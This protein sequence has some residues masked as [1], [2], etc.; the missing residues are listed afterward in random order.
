MSCLLILEAEFL[1]WLIFNTQQPWGGLNY[2]PEFL[3][4]ILPDPRTKPFA[5]TL[6]RNSMTSL[7][8]HTVAHSTRP[9]CRSKTNNQSL[10]KFFNCCGQ[11][12]KNCQKW[13]NS[14]FQGQFAISTIILDFPIFFFIEEYHFRGTFFAFGIFE[15]FNF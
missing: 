13:Q 6:L 9:S 10:E 8:T 15:N 11:L 1:M 3:E 7:L 2:I 4:C 14:D 12:I 5:Y